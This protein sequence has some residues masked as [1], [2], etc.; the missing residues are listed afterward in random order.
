MA[1]NVIR[2]SQKRRW[3]F[4]GTIDKIEV[5]YH[6][7]KADMSPTLKQLADASDRRMAQERKAQGLPVIN[8]SVNDDYRV[9]GTPLILDRAEIR[10]YINVGNGLGSGD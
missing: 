10:V 4:T 6:G 1:D 7:D 2:P 8:G 9:E 3:G 5:F